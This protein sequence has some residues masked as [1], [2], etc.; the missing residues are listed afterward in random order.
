MRAFDGSK[1]MVHGDVDIPIKVGTQTFDSNFCIMDIRPSYS[2]LLGRPLIHNVALLLLRCTKCE[3][4]QFKGRS[5]LFT[6]KKSMA[7]HLNSFRY[8]ELDGEFIETPFQNFEEVPQDVA[9]TKAVSQVPKIT[10]P[11]P[12][13]SYLKDAKAVIEEVGCT[14]WGQLL[15]IPYKSDTFGLGFTSGAHKTVR[16]AR[17]GGPPLKISNCEVNAVEDDEDGCNL[18]D[19][20]FPTISGGLSNSE[21]GDFVPITFIP[22]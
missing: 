9:V 14:I 8:V 19:W 12:R 7:S 16:H 4:I 21:A 1:R 18:E 15:D 5:S 3:N 22:Q 6:E 20:I 17:A 2:F 13:M 11:P 10:R